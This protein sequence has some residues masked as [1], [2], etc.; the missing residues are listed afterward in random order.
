MIFGTAPGTAS[1]VYTL[2]GLSVPAVIN[3]PGFPTSA[4]AITSVGFSQQASV[5][6]MHTLRRLVYIYSFGERMGNVEINGVAFY[7]MCTSPG[8]KNN[9]VVGIMQFYT[10]NSVSNRAFPLSITMASAGLSGFV[11]SIRS[12]FSDTQHGLLGFTISMASLP[13]LWFA[14][15]G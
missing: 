5:Q 7:N 9:G 8:G 3:V 1:Q 4:V 10:N 15:K 2:P 14:S 6:F 12:T 11:Q 13:S